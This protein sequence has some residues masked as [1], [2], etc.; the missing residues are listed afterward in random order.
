MAGIYARSDHEG[1]PATF[2]IPT[3]DANEVMEP[4]HDRM[5]VILPLGREKEWLPP[6]G[7][8][9]FNQ[10]PA[11]LMTAYRRPFLSAVRGK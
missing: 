9:Y 3:T 8:P 4:V 2:A 7:V 6:D 5:L 1:D 10:F 11:E